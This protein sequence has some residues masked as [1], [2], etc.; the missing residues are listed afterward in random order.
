MNMFLSKL[1]RY[2]TLIKSH[3]R[4]FSKLLKS[5]ATVDPANLGAHS[6]GYNLVEGEWKSTEMQKQICDPL[7]G[8]VMLTQ[9]DTQL[10]E[11]EDFIA[12]LEKCPKSGLHNPIK[13]KDRY[14]MLGEVCRKVVE[15][16]QD[17]E[18]WDFFIKCIQ[19]TCPKSEKQTYGELKV[20]IDFFKNFCGDNVR[21]LANATRSPGDHAGQFATGY[22]W[23]YGPVAVIT[24]F[25]FPLEIP[26]LQM[27]G[28][29]FMGNKVLVKPDIKTGMP[30]EQF[31]RL[32]HECGLPKTD[33]SLIYS[34]GPVTE[35]I[36]K[37]APVMQ[38]LFTGSSGIAEHLSK[39]LRGKVR[40][41]D[42]GFDWK[43]LGP[44]VPKDPTKIEYI[45]WQSDQDAYAHSGQKCSA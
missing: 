11:T 45:A 32:L 14:L 27:M 31:V 13:N 8:E 17:K 36:L 4:D 5:F 40:I 15:S 16:M 9:P 42:A 29:L 12:S 38:T 30:L 33:L 24:P 10:S 23:P 22:R 19:R 1:N 39:S 3:Q 43:I 41:E 21:Y 6:K 18:V 20:T 25:N 28:A 44:D 2:S 37:K 35:H 7:T 34:D 26:V